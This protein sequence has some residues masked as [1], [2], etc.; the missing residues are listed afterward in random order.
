MSEADYTTMPDGTY[1]HNPGGTSTPQQYN[2]YPQLQDP[3]AYQ[4]MHT[5]QTRDQFGVNPG[6]AE[7]DVNRLR[8]MGEAAQQRQGA[9]IDNT[10]YDAA[11]QQEIASRIA[12]QGI[13][14]QFGRV[15]S[16]AAPSVAGA[17]Q[18]A[19]LSSNMRA[20]LAGA[21]GARGAG[22]VGLA[23]SVA[24]GQGA[25][26]AAQMIGQAATSRANETSNAFGGQMNMQA[27]MRAQ[28]LQRAGLSADQAYKQAQIEQ[29]QRAYNDQQQLS[30]E[31]LGNQVAA[32]QLAANQ[33]AEQHNANVAAANAQAQRDIDRANQQ[34]QDQGIA[35]AAQTAEQVAG[36]A[37]M[38]A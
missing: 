14:Q 20:Q 10:Q 29:Q 37:A 26:N 24:A 36:L 4:W 3:N 2:P 18:N 25:N 27:E 9:Q 21:A 23:Q 35:S 12:Q 13:G 30:F 5:G 34:R 7:Q 31:Q 33:M 32:Q 19:G 11:R 22:Q 6:G 28:D 38:M 8:G 1:V 15:I 17:Q 16:G